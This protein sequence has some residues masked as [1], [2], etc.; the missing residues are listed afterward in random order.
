MPF[1]YVYLVMLQYGFQFGSTMIFW[2][3]VDTFQERKRVNI[4]INWLLI[5][6]NWGFPRLELTGAGFGTLIT[7]IIIL[8]V[9]IVGALSYNSINQLESDTVM[10]EHTQR[11]IKTSTNL[12]QQ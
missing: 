7:R 12:L 9:F 4:F 3:D 6:G 10:V 1:I 5:Y 2:V 11:V 8:L